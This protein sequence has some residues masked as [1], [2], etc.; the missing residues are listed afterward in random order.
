[1]RHSIIVLAIVSLSLATISA[2][3]AFADCPDG[4]NWTASWTDS[5]GQ[6]TYTLQ[7]PCKAYIGIPFTITATASDAAYPNDDVAYPWYITDNGSTIAGSS[8]SWIT[9]ANGQWQKVVFQTYSGTPINH[10]IQ[11]NFND[12]GT[13]ASGHGYSNNLVGSVTVDP[14][15][16]STPAQTITPV[17]IMEGWWL[18]P[19][20]LAGLGLLYRRRT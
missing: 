13:G 11:F 19:G 20:A 7:A 15:P 18:V 4:S 8:H 5:F 9:T 16:P 3:A 10:T 2:T 14:Y 1:M 17:P 12:L 6:T